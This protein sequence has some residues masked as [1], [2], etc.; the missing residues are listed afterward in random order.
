MSTIYIRFVCQQC[1]KT[2]LRVWGVHTVIPVG[3][4]MGIFVSAIRTY[5][6]VARNLSLVRVV[7]L[8]IA[9]VWLA[10]P[11]VFLWAWVSSEPGN[12]LGG[13]IFLTSAIALACLLLSDRLEAKEREKL[14]L[15]NQDYIVEMASLYIAQR[16]KDVAPKRKRT[17]SSLKK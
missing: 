17:D 9:V 14:I 15:D 2:D 3:Y 4:I 12:N 6:R 5:P 16:K 13:V 7:G 1:G 11:F 10:S 8:P